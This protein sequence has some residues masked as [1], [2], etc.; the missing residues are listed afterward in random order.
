MKNSKKV[1][2]YTN[3]NCPYCDAAKTLLDWN[4][5]E[6]VE[7]D[8]TKLSKNSSKDTVLFKDEDMPKIFFD[9]E[10]IGSYQQLVE[11]IALGKL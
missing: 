10:L 1:T 7:A 3:P 2:L 4:E 6:Y 9:D 8:A 11:L 5:I